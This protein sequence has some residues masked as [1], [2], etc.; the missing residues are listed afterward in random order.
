ML[1]QYEPDVYKELLELI[2]FS[3]VEQIR[4]DEEKCTKPNG[5]ILC[6]NI[7]PIPDSGQCHDAPVH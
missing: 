5:R 7:I 3:F 2:D 1:K 4:R 6:G